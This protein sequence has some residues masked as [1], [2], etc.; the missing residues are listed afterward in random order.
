MI[1][2]SPFAASS[3]EK[4]MMAFLHGMGSEFCDVTLLLEGTA[5]PAHKA[6]LVARSA[7]FE[8]LFRSFEPADKTVK[9]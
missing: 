3:L 8:A 6:I 1:A 2:S 5:I 9:V 7:Y 4:D